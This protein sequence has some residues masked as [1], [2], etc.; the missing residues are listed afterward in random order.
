LSSVVI[1]FVDEALVRRAVDEYASRLLAR[2][3]E[4]EEVVVFGSFADGTYAPGSDLDVFVTLSGS[5]K[6]VRDR[7]AELLP[8]AFPVGVDLFAF[9][10]DEIAARKDSPLIEAVRRSSWRYSRGGRRAY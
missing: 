8:D 5:A 7:I 2:H 4:V 3:S 10:R 1:K 6:S 9:T